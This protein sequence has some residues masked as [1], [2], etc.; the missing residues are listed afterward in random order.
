MQIEIRF[1]TT[2]IQLHLYFYIDDEIFRF[3]QASGN[4]PTLIPWVS[5]L[6]PP[7]KKVEK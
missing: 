5:L 4:Q 7:T 1:I 6:F 2:Y 3:T